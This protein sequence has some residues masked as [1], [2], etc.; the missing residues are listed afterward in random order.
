MIGY[1]IAVERTQRLAYANMLLVYGKDQACVSERFHML[2]R[3]YNVRSQATNQ[4]LLIFI[5]NFTGLHF[6]ASKDP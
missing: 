6:R 4:Y 2:W 5:Q 1:V 3:N